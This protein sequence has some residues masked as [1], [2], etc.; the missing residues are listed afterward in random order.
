MKKVKKLIIQIINIMDSFNYKQ[1]DDKLQE[2]IYAKMQKCKTML[3][4]L[5][6]ETEEIA[7]IINDCKR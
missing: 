6:K 7:K 3:N 2:H 5:N 4:E 1:V